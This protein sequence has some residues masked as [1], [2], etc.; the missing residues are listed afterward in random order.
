MVFGRR[1]YPAWEGERMEVGLPYD[2]TK[3]SAL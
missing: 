1:W 3:K 2:A